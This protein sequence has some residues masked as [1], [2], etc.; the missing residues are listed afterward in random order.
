[1]TPIFKKPN[2]NLGFIGFYSKKP[3]PN[4]HCL[5]YNIADYN[6]F[7]G[8]ILIGPTQTGKTQWA[9]SLGKHSY[10]QSMFSLDYWRE[11]GLPFPENEI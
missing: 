2:Q 10:F 5:G 8:L 7:K 6:R 1:L 3:K 11:E 4:G 9:R